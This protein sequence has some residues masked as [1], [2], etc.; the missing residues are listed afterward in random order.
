MKNV[1][2]FV[3]DLKLNVSNDKIKQ[4]ERNAIRK[5]AMQN[6]LDVMW[7]NGI[8]ADWTGE[9]IAICATN[10]DWGEIDFILDLKVKDLTFD[11]DFETEN[12]KAE[13]ARKEAE[14]KA[15]AEAKAEKIKRDAEARRLKAEAKTE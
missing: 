11:Y 13:V 1:F 5:R 12:Y 10:E 7:A 2:E 3:N 6:L 8:E 9:G 15:K 14:A 4:T